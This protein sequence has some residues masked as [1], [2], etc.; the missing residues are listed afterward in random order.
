MSWTAD[1]MTD[2]MRDHQLHIEIQEDGNYRC[3]LYNENGQLQLRVYDGPGFFI[4]VSW[5]QD[6]IQS[7]SKEVQGAGNPEST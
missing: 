7:F 2:P 4:P 3:R 6:I 1:I 5:L